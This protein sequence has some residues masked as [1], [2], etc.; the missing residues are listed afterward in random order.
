MRRGSRADVV[1]ANPVR[2]GRKQPQRIRRGS[3]R[4]PPNFPL[5]QDRAP[6]L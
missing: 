1:F 6:S 5:R 4:L 2:S 3:F